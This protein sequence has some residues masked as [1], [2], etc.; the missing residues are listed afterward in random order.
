AAG[1]AAL[2][3]SPTAWCTAL[4]AAKLASDPMDCVSSRRPPRL[5]GLSRLSCCRERGHRRP[6]QRQTL[7]TGQAFPSI[8]CRN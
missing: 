6:R 1:A 4:A 8:P 5:S 7:G 3:T 2:P